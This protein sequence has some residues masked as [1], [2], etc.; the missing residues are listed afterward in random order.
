M[1]LAAATYRASGLVRWHLSDLALMGGDVRSSKL[2]RKS[3]HELAASLHPEMT[4]EATSSVGQHSWRGRVSSFVEPI[5]P[6]LYSR[7]HFIT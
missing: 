2:K 4:Q 7:R 1:P 5:D 3:G 6:P